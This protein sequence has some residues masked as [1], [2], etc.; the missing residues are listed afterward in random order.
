MEGTHGQSGRLKRVLTRGRGVFAAQPTET[1]RIDVQ[2]RD[3]ARSPPH[4]LGI[5]HSEPQKWQRSQA[6]RSGVSAGQARQSVEIPQRLIRAKCI[7][8]MVRMPLEMKRQQVRENMVGIPG[9]ATLAGFV[10]VGW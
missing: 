10:A 5:H 8:V 6:E 3:I 7:R 1:V 9:G 4:E 2:L